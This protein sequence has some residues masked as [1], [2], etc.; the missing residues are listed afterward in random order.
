M[1]IAIL[2]TSFCDYSLGAAEALAEKAQVLL[3]TDEITLDRDVS[4][5]AIE[6]AAERIKISLFRQRPFYRKPLAVLKA[7]I[8]IASFRPDLIIAHEQPFFRVAF[9]QWCLKRIA[10][11]ALI[12]HDPVSHSGRDS[13][14][15]QRNARWTR[16]LR[17]QADFFITHGPYCALLLEETGL[18]GK[19]LVVQVP[20]GPILKPERV[21]QLPKN[22]RILMFG[23]MEKYK[24]LDILLEATKLLQK[25]GLKF[26]VRLAG[27][28]PEIERLAH[29][30]VAMDNCTIHAAFIDRSQAEREFAESDIAVAPY[31]DATQ[32]GVVA[33]A[34]AN[35]RPVIVSKVGGLPDF[36]KEEKNGLLVPSGNPIALADGLERVLRDPV[37]LESLHEGALLS[38]GTEMSWSRFTDNILESFEIFKKTGGWHE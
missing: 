20:H 9:L 1:K 14:L 16:Q 12:V 23:R 21:A 18:V 38:I 15:A 4:K 17:K 36:V 32:S 33:A 34:F 24:G 5:N 22:G 31:T 10:P 37:L 25:R 8:A 26:E 29:E 7:F 6:K 19:R 28:G 3:A 2:A 35:G 11:L 27:A 30:F 13:H